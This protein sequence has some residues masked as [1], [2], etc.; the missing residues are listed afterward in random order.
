MTLRSYSVLDI[1]L[2]PIIIM[3][4]DC[5]QALSTCKV[6]LVEVCL[7]CSSSYDY[8]SLSLQYMGLYVFNWPILV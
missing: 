8:L 6:Y 7:T 3:I 1:L 2:P 5:S 4:Q